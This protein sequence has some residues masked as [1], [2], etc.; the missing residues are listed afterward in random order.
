MSRTRLAAEKWEIGEALDSCLTTRQTLTN[1]FESP[2][3]DVIYW[4]LRKVGGRSSS[5]EYRKG[6]ERNEQPERP[7]WNESQW[8]NG[9][10]MLSADSTQHNLSKQ[11]TVLSM[12]SST[13][14]YS[15]CTGT[16]LLS[17]SLS[18][19][20]TV[21]ATLLGHVYVCVRCCERQSWNVSR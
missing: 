20:Q 10:P 7:I 3:E 11:A 9:P 13:R 5:A 16:Y 6:R 2:L 12:M 4:V 19:S 8:R 17:V 1:E 15:T 14:S 21:L 18:E